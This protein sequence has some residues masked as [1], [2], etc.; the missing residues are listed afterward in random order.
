M[1]RKYCIPVYH[2]NS[3]ENIHKVFSSFEKGSKNLYCTKEEGFWAGN[4]MY[5]WDNKGNAAYWKRTRENRKKLTSATLMADLLIDDDSL[6][7]LTD[8]EVLNTVNRLWP[9][10]AERFNL[11]NGYYSIGKKINCICEMIPEIKVV[12]ICGYYP[13]K[14]EH[15]F[16]EKEKKRPHVTLKSKIIFCVKASDRLQDLSIISLD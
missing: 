1:C 3:P 12:K 14:K 16:L 7:D 5:F 6:L 4:G 15:S 2:V 10:V 8:Q 13:R 11:N 9:R